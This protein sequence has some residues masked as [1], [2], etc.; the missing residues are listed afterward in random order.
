MPDRQI[1]RVAK[2]SLFHD[3]KQAL[4]RCETVCFSVRNRHFQNGF[5]MRLQRR[6]KIIVN[7][8]VLFLKKNVYFRSHE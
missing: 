5:L 3:V 4:L 1:K 2:K 8:N 7:L 6:R